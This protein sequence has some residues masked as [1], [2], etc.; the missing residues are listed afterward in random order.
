M[1]RLSAAERHTS[2]WQRDVDKRTVFRLQMTTMGVENSQKRSLFG[3][4]RGQGDDDDDDEVATGD[5]RLRQQR[6]QIRRPLSDGPSARWLIDLS[7]ALH[8]TGIGKM[9]CMMVERK[10]RT[11]FQK[12]VPLVSGEYFAHWIGNIGITMRRT[13]QCF[14]FVMHIISANYC[15]RA[16][17]HGEQMT[18]D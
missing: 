15:S 18:R 14:H 9:D 11:A 4:R 16:I 2:F 10:T 3:Q 1:D 7:T 13:D 17:V 8:D 6:G 5:G 12:K